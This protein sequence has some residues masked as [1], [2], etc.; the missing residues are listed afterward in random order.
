MSAVTL[1]V[2]L[3]TARDIREITTKASVCARLSRRGRTSSID[4][5]TV[6]SII[7]SAK[8]QGRGDC[9]GSNQYWVAD[10]GCCWRP[11]IITPMEYDKIIAQ[12]LPRQVRRIG[13]TDDAAEA[14][15][16]SSSSTPMPSESPNCRP[17]QKHW[18]RLPYQRC[19]SRCCSFL[20][21]PEPESVL[22]IVQLRGR[23]TT[24][25]RPRLPAPTVCRRQGP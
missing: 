20:D 12:R 17:P 16:T 14:R 24:R 23:R 13:H 15:G 4:P 6:H 11:G 7:T 19:G 21:L 22:V 5:N 2:T 9:G 3:S 8:L 10:P 18:S 25:R 1:A